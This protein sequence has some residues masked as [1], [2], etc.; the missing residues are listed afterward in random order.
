M[1]LSDMN[2]HRIPDPHRRQTSTKKKSSRN[3]TIARNYRILARRSPCKTL[4]NLRQCVMGALLLLPRLVHPLPR[5][6]TPTPGPVMLA[7]V[8]CKVVVSRDWKLCVMD[9]SVMV[10]AGGVVRAGKGAW[11]WFKRE[12]VSR[13]KVRGGSIVK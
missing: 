9:V 10:G 13:P 11:G 1:R 6:R 3:Y 4:V 2:P 7:P 12:C 8:R 5:H